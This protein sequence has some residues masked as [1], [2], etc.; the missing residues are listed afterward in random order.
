MAVIYVLT[1]IAV[2]GHL[3][4][5]TF[6]EVM[7]W[8]LLQHGGQL[9]SDLHCCPRAS[10]RADIRRVRRWRLLQHGGHLCLTYIAVLGRLDGQ[11]FV[12]VY[13]YHYECAEA[14]EARGG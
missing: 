2:L 1:Y 4:G 14:A 11:T 13:S 7:R 3:E 10:G 9:W 12:E 6:D 5:Q 8:R